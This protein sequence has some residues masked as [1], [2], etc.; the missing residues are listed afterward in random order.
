MLL[1]NLFIPFSTGLGFIGTGFFFVSTTFYRFGAFAFLIYHVIQFLLPSHIAL[2]CFIVRQI[3]LPLAL[4]VPSYLG[5]RFASCEVFFSDYFLKI[6]LCVP[7]S[8]KVMSS[9]RFRA[10]F[11]PA[12]KRDV[13]KS[14]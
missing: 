6:S 10:S 13:F 2:P 14:S 9:P 4:D 1:K 7:V 5:C 12:L 11:T 8:T 3:P